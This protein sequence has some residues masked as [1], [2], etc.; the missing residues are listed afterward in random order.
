MGKPGVIQGL[1]A[2][3]KKSS[4]NNGG[5]KHSNIQNIGNEVPNK[6][7]VTKCVSVT[8]RPWQ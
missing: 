3:A 7:L 5:P 8:S 4:L 2:V 6:E 1:T